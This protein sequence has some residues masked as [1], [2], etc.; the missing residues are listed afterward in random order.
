[1]A[2]WVY[3]FTEGDAGMRNLLGGKGANLAEMTNIGLPVPQG[4]TITTEACTQYYEDGREINE[5]IQGQI[6][7]YIVKMEQQYSMIYKELKDVKEML[8]NMHNPSLKVRLSN[9]FDKLDIVLDSGKDRINQ[10]KK[11]LLSSMKTASKMF[12]QN[13]KLAAIKTVDVLHLKEAL[14][15]IRKSLFISLRK[16]D[17]N[18]LKCDQI[19]LEVRKSKHNIKNIVQIIKTGNPVY[20]DIDSNKLNTVQRSLRSIR[21]KIEN[22]IYSTTNFLHKLEEFEKPS[23]KSEIKLLEKKLS[24]NDKVKTRVNE[25]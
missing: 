16:I 8:N 3:L 19:S 17:S 13:G 11:E 2:K 6:N 5:E 14:S 23:V 20:S 22:M 21:G 9:S 7:E 24:S 4:F 1:M 25:R 18:I 10:V 15:G 12:K